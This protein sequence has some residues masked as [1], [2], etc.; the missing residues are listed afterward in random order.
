MT[1]FK[2]YFSKHMFSK[3]MF[4]WTVNKTITSHNVKA[5]TQIKNYHT[6]HVGNGISQGLLNAWNNSIKQNLHV[7]F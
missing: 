7:K 4:L 6:F 2:I 5:E 3:H 1:S